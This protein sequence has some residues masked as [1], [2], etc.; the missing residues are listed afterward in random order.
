MYISQSH[1]ESLLQEFGVILQ[2]FRH[3]LEGLCVA[4]TQLAHLLRLSYPELTLWARASFPTTLLA[5]ELSQAP[6]CTEIFFLSLGRLV[7]LRIE[8]WL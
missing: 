1:M 7:S 2:I 4:N 5:N 3:E 6:L 8:N